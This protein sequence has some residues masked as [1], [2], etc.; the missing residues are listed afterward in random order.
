MAMEKSVSYKVVYKLAS[1]TE[2]HDLISCLIEHYFD[3]RKK[4]L[5]VSDPYELYETLQISLSEVERVFS[6]FDP[7]G[8]LFPELL[9]K[10]KA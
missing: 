9:E 10:I 4:Q 5:A 1:G 2:N 7:T 3:A 8:E 6:K